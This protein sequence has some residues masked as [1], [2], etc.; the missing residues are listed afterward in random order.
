MTIQQSLSECSSSY[1]QIEGYLRH[2]SRVGIPHYV[3]RRLSRLGVLENIEAVDDD[4][5]GSNEVRQA[6]INVPM[7]PCPE[8]FSMSN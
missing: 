5:L 8:L 3:P 6:N 7:N 2:G 4:A 1:A